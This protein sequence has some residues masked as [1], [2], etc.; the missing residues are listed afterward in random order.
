MEGSTPEASQTCIL[1]D[2]HEGET[3]S[4][5]K[6]MRAEGDNADENTSKRR[7]GPLTPTITTK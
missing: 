1:D 7:K 5:T 4:G 2:E 3:L 6:K